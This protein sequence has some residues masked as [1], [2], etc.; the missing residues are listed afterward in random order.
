MRG[1]SARGGGGVQPSAAYTLDGP[2]LESS[3][4]VVILVVEKQLN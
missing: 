4:A 1:A 2:V 3:S